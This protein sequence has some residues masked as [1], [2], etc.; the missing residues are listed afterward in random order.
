MDDP[1]ANE[2]TVLPVSTLLMGVAPCE[3]V[4]RTSWF[5]KCVTFTN[6]ARIE[7]ARGICQNVDADLVIDMNEEPFG[8][9]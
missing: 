1:D 8:D 5:T 9:D 4:S 6:E 3:R 2:F 7:I